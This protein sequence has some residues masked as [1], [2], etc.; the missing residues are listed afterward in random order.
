MKITLMVRRD[1]G[2]FWVED[3]VDEYSMEEWNGLLP[4]PMQAK[5]DQDPANT[6]LVVLQVPDETL[7]RAF[8]V[9]IVPA[10]VIR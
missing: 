4:G 9:P 5:I 2:V 1:E 3:A 10:Q 8:D 6:R 7:E